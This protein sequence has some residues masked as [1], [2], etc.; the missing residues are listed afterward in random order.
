MTE[1]KRK[2]L[3]CYYEQFVVTKW[4]NGCIYDVEKIGGQWFAMGD[5]PQLNVQNENHEFWVATTVA[6]EFRHV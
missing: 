1:S 5:G 4:R 6:P 2:K 3:C